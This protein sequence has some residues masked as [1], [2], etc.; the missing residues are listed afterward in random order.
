MGRLVFD[1]LKKV[2]L[3]LM[4]VCHIAISLTARYDEIDL[5]GR[6]VHGIYHGLRQCLPRNAAST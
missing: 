1:N 2:I 3:Y 4:P 6:H 5:A